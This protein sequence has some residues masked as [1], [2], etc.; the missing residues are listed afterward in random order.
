[1]R[2][3]SFVVAVLCVL[4][5]SPWARA[6]PPQDEPAAAHRVVGLEAVAKSWAMDPRDAVVLDPNKLMLGI[7]G[8]ALGS[9]T[10]YAWSDNVLGHPRFTMAWPGRRHVWN[11]ATFIPIDPT[12]YPIYVATYRATRVVTPRFWDFHVM[13]PTRTD[14]ENKYSFVRPDNPVTGVSMIGDGK[15]RELRVDMRT[16]SLTPDAEVFVAN[17]LTSLWLGVRAGLDTPAV[18]ELVGLR[19]ESTAETRRADPFAD[20]APIQFRVTDPKGEAIGGAEVALDAQRINFARRGKS[21]AFGRVSLTPL[22]NAAGVHTV[23]VEKE[24]W[25]PAEF[26]D[27]R[28]GGDGS[29]TLV[30]EKAVVYR[31]R[32]VDERGAGIPNVAVRM[33]PA[34]WRSSAT[35]G[36]SLVRV[37]VATGPDGRWISPPMPASSEDL[38]LRLTHIDYVSDPAAEVKA[39]HSVEQLVRDYPVAVMRD[40]VRVRGQVRPAPGQTLKKMESQLTLGGHSERMIRWGADDG[41]FDLGTIEPGAATLT[42]KARGHQDVV[43]DLAQYREDTVLD[44]QLEE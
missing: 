39:G 17:P 6:M 34:G 12:T 24:G 38:C 29:V 7:S 31:G 4:A 13:M 11:G 30:L 5:V 25:M 15:L 27:L 8:C 21:D 2:S 36:R 40:G 28:V 9:H 44:V 43:I 32:V 23:R 19:M 37:A 26:D 1:M 42:L 3:F 35:E 10:D 20:E 33:Y 22:E 41:F 14:L 16:V 18:F